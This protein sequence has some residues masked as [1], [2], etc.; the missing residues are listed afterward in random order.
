MP[1]PPSPSSLEPL[2]PLESGRIRLQFWDLLGTLC[3]PEIQDPLTRLFEASHGDTAGFLANTGHFLSW[4]A[5]FRRDAEA[6]R[7]PKAI[8]CQI[9][10]ERWGRG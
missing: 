3:P 10:P 9:S 1:Q 2:S 4:G 8:L 5:C 7:T 6:G